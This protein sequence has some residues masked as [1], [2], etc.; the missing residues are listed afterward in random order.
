MPFHSDGCIPP[1]EGRPRGTP[2]EF[3]EAV[4]KKVY[5]GPVYFRR[6][7]RIEGAGY[8]QKSSNRLGAGAA[9]T[10]VP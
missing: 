3:T 8:R 4:A 7:E 2:G 6:V 5:Y 1:A 10:A 9:S